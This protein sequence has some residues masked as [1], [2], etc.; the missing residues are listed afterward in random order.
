MGNTHGGIWVIYYMDDTRSET[1]RLPILL[2]AYNRPA[3]IANQLKRLEGEPSRHVHVYIDGA[4]PESELQQDL[5][6]KQAEKWADST[7][8]KPFIHVNNLNFGIRNH[9][10]YAAQRFFSNFPK[11]IVLEDDITFSSDFFEY[12]EFFLSN[13]NSHTF[14]SICGYNPILNGKSGFRGEINSFLTAVHTIWGWAT[15]SLSIEHY[16]SFKT[17][18]QEKILEQIDSFSRNFTI[19][20]RLQRSIELTWKRKFL[21][22]VSTAGGGSW[23]NAWLLAGWHSKKLSVMP[24]VSLSEETTVENERGT[25]DGTRNYKGSH[26]F[27]SLGYSRSLAPKRRNRDLKLM[28]VWGITRAYSWLY[29]RRIKKQLADFVSAQNY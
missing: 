22:S 19:D 10:P 23:D 18:S 14:W 13:H 5:V 26:D 6:I 27:Q 21:R 8:H 20:T 7:K 28:K 17:M 16:L 12:C 1:P 25:H 4:K 9:F 29:S 24:S 15:S 3:A 2:I 11:G